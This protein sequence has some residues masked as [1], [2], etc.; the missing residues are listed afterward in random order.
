MKILKMPEAFAVRY[1]NIRIAYPKRFPYSI[2]FYLDDHQA[3]V[4]ITAI[5]HNKRQL[6]TAR[7][8]IK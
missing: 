8:R 7:K 5:I 2:H 1:K 4:V 3:T 6:K